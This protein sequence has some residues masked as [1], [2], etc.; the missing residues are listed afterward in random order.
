MPIFKGP[1]ILI[2]KIPSCQNMTGFLY[3][4]EPV[5]KLNSKNV[6]QASF[7]K[8]RTGLACVLTGIVQVLL[9]VLL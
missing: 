5:V 4:N 2:Q 3:G 1:L 7:D 8:L 9:H 6:A